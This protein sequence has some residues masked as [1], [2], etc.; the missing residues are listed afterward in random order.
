M[1]QKKVKKERL[2]R[3]KP[4]FVLQ[5]GGGASY[6]TAHVNTSSVA[7][8]GTLNKW[9]PAG[10]LRLMWYPRYRLRLG[11]ETGFTN[12]YRY[13]VTDTS[14]QGQVSLQAIPLLVVWSM[15][16]LPRLNIYAGFGSY[17]LK[18]ISI[19]KALSIQETG[20]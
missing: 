3:R 11:L 6:Y 17:I 13:K 8:T 10:T 18:P 4:S 5:A 7:Y 14:G 1:A 9:S 16:V 15:Q 20:F 12:F 19:I 2:P